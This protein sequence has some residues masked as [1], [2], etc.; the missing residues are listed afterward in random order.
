MTSDEKKKV[1]SSFI[2]GSLTSSAGVFLSKLVGLLY[3]SPLHSLATLNNMD[4][5]SAAYNYY[6]VLLQICSA[7]LP[8]AVAAIIAKYASK[9]DWK[10]VMLVRRLSI[11]I[12][13]AFGFA[14]AV[15]FAAVS[16]PLSSSVLGPEATAADLQK[17]KIT[18]II[19][20]LAL[21]L[22]PILYSYRSF[23]QGLK[24]LK[25]Y[26]DSQVIEQFVRV[27]FLLG[28]GWVCIYIFGL[29]RVWAVY[30]AALGTSIGALGALFYYLRYDRRHIGPIRRAAR[31][32]TTRP[33]DHKVLM[34]E[35]FAF[36]VPYLIT[37]IFG[38]S[39]VLVNTQFFVSTMTSMGM[40][41]QLARNLYTI[42]QLNCDKLTSIPQVLGIG[43][44]SGIV[45]Y[46]T[47]SLEQRN[48]KELR[49]NIRACLDTVLY[50]GIPVCWALFTLARPIYFVLYGADRLDYAEVC[51][52][53]EALLALCTTITPICTSMMLTLHLRKESIFYLGVGF[54]VKCV[55]FYPLMRATGYTGAITSSILCSAAIIYLSLAKIHNRYKVSYQA[56]LVRAVKMLLA[57][58]AISGAFALMKL[59][60][61]EISLSSRPMAL[62]G[63]AAYAAV[64]GLLYLYLTMQMKIPQAIFHVSGKGALRRILRQGRA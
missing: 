64:D 15:I 38:N 29:D 51:M 42:I 21:F 53:W 36:G 12:L 55:T 13:S 3:V 23:Y 27:G 44:S 14:M 56:T 16:G 20:S 26:A 2:A 60:G 28:M 9:D 5:Y 43:F 62:L 6:S 35:L 46:M 25:S 10:T 19:L 8:Y 18:F 48:F 22:V 54:A 30:M 59:A 41:Y 11:G 49:K 1:K 4:Y 32:Q 57:C 52:Q 7:G 50:I 47:I 31:N 39:Q 40:D 61:L 17:Q 45:P 33:V 58:F 24:D 34:K 37:A 63:L